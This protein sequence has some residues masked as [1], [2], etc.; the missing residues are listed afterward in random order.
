MAVSKRTRFEVLRRDK[1]TCQY[2]GEKAPDVTLHVDHVIPV[3]LGGS[4]KPDNL[5][6]ACKDCHFGK[7]SISPDSPLVAA[8]A[9]RSAEY[10]LANA[11]RAAHM[12]ADLRAMADYCD[13]FHLTWDESI[14]SNR[15][16]HD[17]ERS[18]R[19]WWS[20]TVPQSALEYAVSTAASNRDVP[21]RDKFRYFAGVVW[22]QIDDYNLRYPA[23][24]NSGPVYSDHQ[25]EEYGMSEWRR[26]YQQGIDAQKRECGEHG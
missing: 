15:L 1:H 4:D 23:A 2:C 19:T 5:V 12:D 10:V 7:P 8:V 16:P 17:W 3:A 13:E 14:G 21:F 18:I 26:G 24:T 11:N 9:E 6:A 20:M 25:V 22:R